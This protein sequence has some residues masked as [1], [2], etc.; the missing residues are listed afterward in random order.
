MEQPAGTQTNLVALPDIKEF[1]E[2]EDVF[3]VD[4]NCNRSSLTTSTPVKLPSQ[5]RIIVLQDASNL[6]IY[7]DIDSLESIEDVS[8][9]TKYENIDYEEE[10]EESG[11]F[12]DL[13]FSL[14]EDEAEATG[15]KIYEDI[16]ESFAVD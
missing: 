14:Y 9:I 15:F 11:S 12:Q 13:V 2:E 16:G 7:E 4:I 1:I 8:V 6:K 5:S 3:K 10:E